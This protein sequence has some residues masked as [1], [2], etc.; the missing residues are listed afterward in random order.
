M[1]R[2]L[3]DTGF[4]HLKIAFAEAL[5]SFKGFLAVVGDIVVDALLDVR[6]DVIG[7]SLSQLRNKVIDLKERMDQSWHFINILL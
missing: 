3:I 6:A 7:A 4:N 1:T 5:E 2:S